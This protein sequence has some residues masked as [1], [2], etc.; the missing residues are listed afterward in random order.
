ML[1]TH[2]LGVVA[3]MADK[4]AVMYAG[5]IVEDA[6]VYSLFREPLHPYTQGA[7]GQH[8]H[9]RHGRDERLNVINGTVPEPAALAVGCRFAPRC[10]Y[11]MDICREVKPT[12]QRRERRPP[13]QLLA[14]LAMT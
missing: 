1:I 12:L 5:E 3:E 6:D 10:P 4:V 8:S 13:C 7:A 9:A 14:L 2:D 11:V